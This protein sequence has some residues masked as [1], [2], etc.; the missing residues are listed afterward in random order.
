MKR[1]HAHKT[2]ENYLANAYRRVENSI[3]YDLQVNEWKRSTVET[4]K[5]LAFLSLSNI[6][7]RA[8]IPTIMEK[9]AHKAIK[10]FPFMNWFRCQVNYEINSFNKHTSSTSFVV[11]LAEWKVFTRALQRLI[12]FMLHLM[13]FGVHRSQFCVQ[14]NDWANSKLIDRCKR[15][16]H[17]SSSKSVTVSHF[18]FAAENE[19]AKCIS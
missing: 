16:S 12:N 9:F 2:N 7:H 1:N 5:L 10:W 3:I 19:L 15:K 14:F 4:D 6:E 13:M 8:S 18:A 11:H 17:K